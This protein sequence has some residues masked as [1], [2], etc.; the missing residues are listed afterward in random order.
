M[1]ITA[2]CARVELPWGFRRIFPFS[3]VPWISPE[4][5]AHCM[6]SLAQALTEAPSGNPVR[7]AVVSS[8]W[9]LA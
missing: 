8:C 9:S 4:P 5:T 1:R 6:A 3:S 2:T 7:V